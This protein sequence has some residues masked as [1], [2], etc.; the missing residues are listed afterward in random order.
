MSHSRALS[1]PAHLIPG[2]VEVGKGKRK[3]RV[4]AE[5]GGQTSE[6]TP[7]RAVSLPLAASWPRVRLHKCS[8]H[9]P[10]CRSTRHKPRTL[11]LRVHL[12]AQGA[13]TCVSVHMCIA[14]CSMRAHAFSKLG[15]VLRDCF[16]NHRRWQSRAKK[17]ERKKRGRRSRTGSI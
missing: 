17:Q 3:T 7:A 4:V 13:P 15:Q 6:G 11:Y 16:D 1:C 2:M 14:E 8:K 9:A 12:L 5:H 10:A